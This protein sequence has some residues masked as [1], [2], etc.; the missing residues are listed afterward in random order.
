M[1]H[2][3][4]LLGPFMGEGPPAAENIDFSKAMIKGNCIFGTPAA[5]RKFQGGGGWG[6]VGEGGGVNVERAWGRGLGLSFFKKK[7][8]PHRLFK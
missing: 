8:V 7:K 2:A 1:V 4:P 5:R 6:W 3:H